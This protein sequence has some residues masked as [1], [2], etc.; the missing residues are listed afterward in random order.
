M[1]RR[2]LLIG[3]LGSGAL[4]ITTPICDAFVPDSKPQPKKTISPYEAV[5]M[6]YDGF[7]SQPDTEFVF[8]EPQSSED[9]GDY[10]TV[11][12]KL[13]SPA[14]GRHKHHD[15]WLIFNDTR[16]LICG[17]EIKT[18]EIIVSQ[19]LCKDAHQLNSQEKYNVEKILKP[20]W[21]QSG[22]HVV[23]VKEFNSEKYMEQNFQ[24]GPL[25]RSGLQ[26]CDDTEISTVNHF[27][28]L[29]TG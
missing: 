11:S 13:I 22:R 1:K 26:H 2:S 23:Y 21:M 24:T 8:D 20:S 14:G 17:T 4:A 5:K 10:N 3:S 7:S 6:V 28:S 19:V 15:I 29:V 27:L 18:R 16:R 25:F 9:V 12:C